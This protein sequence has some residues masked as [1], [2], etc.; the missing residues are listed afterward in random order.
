[1]NFTRFRLEIS[2]KIILPTQ[3]LHDL[4]AENMLF[5]SL[6]MGAIPGN[7]AKMHTP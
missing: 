4:R 3:I 6:N 5:H 7:M 2:D 1:M